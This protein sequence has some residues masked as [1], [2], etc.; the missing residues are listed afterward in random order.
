MTYRLDVDSIY[1]GND[2]RT[3]DAHAIG[4]DTDKVAIFF[5]QLEICLVGVSLA[6]DSESPVVGEFGKEWSRNV[7]ESRVSQND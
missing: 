2:I 6:D 3:T 1:Q 4:S 5:V 7:G